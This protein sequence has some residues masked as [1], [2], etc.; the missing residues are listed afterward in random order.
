MISS[1]SEEG[2]GKR[3]RR[4]AEKEWEAGKMRELFTGDIDFPEISDREA[5][6]RNRDAYKRTQSYA[7]GALAEFAQMG[8][9]RIVGSISSAEFDMLAEK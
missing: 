9:F 8:S 6:G 4:N 2:R 1:H 3:R 5:I 7:Y